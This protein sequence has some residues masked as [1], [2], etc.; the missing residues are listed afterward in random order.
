MVLVV[1]VGVVGVTIPIN[2]ASDEMEN[3][4]VCKRWVEL[5]AESSY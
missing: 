4:A 3:S 5:C 1:L 2:F